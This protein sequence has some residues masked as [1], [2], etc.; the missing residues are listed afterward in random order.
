MGLN[1]SV[2]SYRA[3]TSTDLFRT[4]LLTQS[5]EYKWV[6]VA[7]SSILKCDVCAH[8]N[9]YIFSN[10]PINILRKTVLSTLN[11]SVIS[12]INQMFI[13]AYICFQTFYSVLFLYLSMPAPMLYF[14]DYYSFS[15]SPETCR[16][17][18]LQEHIVS[19]WPFE[20]PHECCIKL[21]NT[22]RAD[23]LLR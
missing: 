3:G 23:F 20:I 18:S 21:L 19:S 11:L 2:F 5:D 1:L 7:P 14:Y 10:F 6:L 15:I 22:H 12:V 8:V 9:F 4:A 17:C 13:F 16:T